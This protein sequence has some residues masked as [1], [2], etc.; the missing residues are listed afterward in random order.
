MHTLISAFCNA[1]LIGLFI[2]AFGATFGRLNPL[3]DLF[4]QFVLPALVG[5]VVIALIALMTA[6]Y[7]TALVAVA[8]LLVNMLIAWPWIQ[9]PTPA[10][11]HGPTVKVLLFNIYYYN[12]RLDEAA[13]VVRELNPDIVIL[14]EVIPRVRPDLDA[15]VDAFPY[16][17]ESWLERP[18]DALILSRFPLED[19]AAELPVPKHRR[20]LGAAKVTIGERTLTLFAAHLSLPPLLEGKGSQMGEM[21]EIAETINTRTGP[22][23]LVGDFNASTW[24]AVITHART[25]AALEVLTGPSG[26]WPTFL[27]RDLGIPIDHMLAS[28]EITFVSRKLITIPGSDHRAVLAEIKFKN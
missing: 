14:H 26:S 10:E 20:P 3:I 22:R 21:H 13:K 19:L 28:Q 7:G 27:P 24:G 17:V 25:F 5:A 16:R 6:R 2:V 9:N 23:L 18:A 12:R 4:G 8:A 11:A 15:M 1:V